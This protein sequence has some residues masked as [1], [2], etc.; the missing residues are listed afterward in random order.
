VSRTNSTFIK[1]VKEGS[2]TKMDG[3]KFCLFNII[4]T[5]IRYRYRLPL[6]LVG[7]VKRSSRNNGGWKRT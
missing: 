3:E 7:I 1:L 2:D 4:I 5:I 6:K